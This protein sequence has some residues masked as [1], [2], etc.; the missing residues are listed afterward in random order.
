MSS[1]VEALLD[2]SYLFGF[3]RRRSEEP[4]SDKKEKKVQE[5][6]AFISGTGLNL[7]LEYFQISLDADELR[8]SF[9]QIWKR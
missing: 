2:A 4:L 7:A 5:A 3:R 8:S 1:I 6:Y 9:M